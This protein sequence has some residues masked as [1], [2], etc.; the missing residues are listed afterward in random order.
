MS[1]VTGMNPNDVPA[2]VSVLVFALVWGVTK[3]WENKKREGEAKARKED[4]EKNRIEMK[5]IR[6]D[7]ADIHGDVK[8]LHAKVENLEGKSTTKD[9]AQNIVDILF[10]AGVLHS[11]QKSDTP[12]PPSTDKPSRDRKMTKIERG[13]D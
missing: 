3:H 8:V 12:D 13:S 10:R 1:E 4:A 9:L 2:W 5:E 11:T 7:I 6:S